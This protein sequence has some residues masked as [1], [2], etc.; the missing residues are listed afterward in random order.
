MTTSELQIIFSAVVALST[1]IQH[2]WHN[3]KK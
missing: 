3:L 1:V 2:Q